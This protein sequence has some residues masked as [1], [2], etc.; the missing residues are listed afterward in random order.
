MKEHLWKLDSLFYR[1]KETYRKHIILLAQALPGSSG[2]SRQA[3]PTSGPALGPAGPG[4]MGNIGNHKMFHLSFRMNPRLRLKD[5]MGVYSCNIF[6]HQ[7]CRLRMKGPRVFCHLF[8]VR[9]WNM[10]SLL[11][12]V[13]GAAETNIIGVQSD[14][15]WKQ[16]LNSAISIS[17]CRR[18]HHHHHHHHP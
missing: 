11:D 13:S 15:H 17:S 9:P 10:H 5:W 1:L 16:T 12:R 18:R 3:S 14:G 2:P 4:W 6:K 7:M 8:F